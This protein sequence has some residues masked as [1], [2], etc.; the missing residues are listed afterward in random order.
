MASVLGEYRAYSGVAEMPTVEQ[1][2]VTYANF[3]HCDPDRDIAIIECDRERDDAGDDNNGAV[4]GYL[5]PRWDDLATGTRDCSLFS[6]LRVA[7]LSRPLFVA[8]VDGQE[9]HML[10]WAAEKPPARWRGFAVHP[11]PGRAGDR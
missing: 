9:R 2:D 11:G 8:L 1:M 4:V 7:H 3:D 5:R 6:P 10:P